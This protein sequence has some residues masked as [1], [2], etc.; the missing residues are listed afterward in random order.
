MYRF[1]VSTTYRGSL[2]PHMSL[3]DAHFVPCVHLHF[4]S[5]EK[6]NVE[7]YLKDNV[8]ANMTSSDAANILASKYRYISEIWN[9]KNKNNAIWFSVTIK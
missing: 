7:P 2:E 6:E 5:S 8:Y 9:G 4:M 1:P 3:A